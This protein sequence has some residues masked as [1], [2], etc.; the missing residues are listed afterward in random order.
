VSLLHVLLIASACTA[1]KDTIS[2]VHDQVDKGAN[3]WAVKVLSDQGSGTLSDGTFE[4]SCG[5]YR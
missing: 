2:L 1:L 5:R 3:I 4:A